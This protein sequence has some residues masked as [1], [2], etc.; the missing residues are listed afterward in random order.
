EFCVVKKMCDAAHFPVRAN[1]E[2]VRPTPE[3]NH[4]PNNR[5]PPWFDC[6]PKTSVDCVF[7]SLIT[8]PSLARSP[9]SHKPS[10]RPDRQIFTWNGT[11]RFPWVVCRFD[12]WAIL[13]AES[14]GAALGV[15]KMGWIDRLGKWF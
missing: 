11:F 8:A 2:T 1:G 3:A 10:C 12:E 9:D 13:N 7:Y 5:P 4:A 6:K 14:R 15:R